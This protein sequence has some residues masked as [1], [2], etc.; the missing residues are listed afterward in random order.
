M[1][2]KTSDK[3]YGQ[4]GQQQAQYIYS[5]E[6]RRGDISHCIGQDEFSFTAPSV[7]QDDWRGVCSVVTDNRCIVFGVVCLS[8]C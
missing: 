5:A 2:G 4:T 3:V 7:A 6:A 1:A 8:R